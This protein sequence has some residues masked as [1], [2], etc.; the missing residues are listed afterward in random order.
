MKISK[1]VGE[2]VKEAPA[3]VTA[4]SHILLLRAGY[5]KQV[6][7][8]IYSLMPAAQRVALKIENI[9]REEMDAIDGQ[10]VLFPVVMPKELWE[11]SG[12]YY[13]I[14]QEM[15]RFKD[16]NNHDMLLGM[17]HE[18]AAVHMCQNTVKSYDQLPFMIYQIQTKFRDEARPRAGLLRVKEFTMKDGYSFH[19]S[20]EDL[21]NYYKR[22][23]DAYNRIYKRIGMK[24]FVSV[25]SDTGMMGGGRADEFQLLIDAGE[26]NIVICSHCDY[27]S[28]MEVANSIIEKVSFKDEKIKE[29]YTGEAKT[30]D[31]VSK[32][33]KIS[34]SQTIKAVCYAVVG[35]EKKV[36][37]VFIRGDREV[38]EAKLKSAL[39]CDIAVKDLADS[40]LV[41]GNIGCLNLKISDATIVFDNTLKD[42]CGMVTGANKEGYHISGVNVS[43]D[44]KDA[45]FY[46]IAKVNEGDKCPVCGKP[47]TIKKGIEVGNIFQLGTKYTK[48]MGMTIQMPDGSSMNPIMGC[49]GI[50]VGRCLAAVVEEKADDKGIVWP[51]SI[52][53]WQIYLCPL[54]TEDERVLN[55]SEKLYKDLSKSFEVLYD[56]RKVSAGMKLTDSELMGIPLRIVVSPRSIENDEAEVLI[57]ESGEKKMI[58]LSS[59]EKELRNIIKSM[60][61]Y[62]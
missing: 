25:S 22:A 10:E 9:I 3:G 44:V 57:R 13:S 7:N 8:G 45:V 26:D 31:E 53:P 18:E 36:V 30:I 62:E 28:N 38:N 23:Y 2:R 47:L 61:D 33:M 19:T 46:D 27:K 56:D 32:F 17:T 42:A 39:G 6:S 29:V 4:K 21:E 52:A 5:I 37:I 59:L 41:K 43:R 55:I 11:K 24:N 35:D 12:R 16:R 14:G 58:K 15:V 1:L 51:M 40:G 48:S 49:Y 60:V 20:Q 50:G 54:K 34:P